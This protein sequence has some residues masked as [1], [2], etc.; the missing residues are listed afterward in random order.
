MRSARKCIGLTR[1]KIATR[2]DAQGLINRLFELMMR[3]LNIAIFMGNAQVV[4]RWPHCVMRSPGENE[5][6]AA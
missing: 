2:S 4:L 1:G 3:L 5:E 6:A